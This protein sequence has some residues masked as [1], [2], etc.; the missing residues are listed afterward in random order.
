MAE[1]DIHALEARW[2]ARWRATGLHSTDLDGAR[3]PF[4]NLMEFPYPSGEGLHVG[5]VY[6]YAGADA[7]GRL[8]RMQGYDVFQPMGFDAFGIHSENYALKVGAHPAALIPANIARFRDEQLARLG[9]AFDWS[10]QLSTT[11]PAYYRWTQW[12]FVQL[13]R[14]GLA[15]QAEA[16]VNW[17]PRDQ[18]VLANEQV[19]GG[20]CERCDTPVERRELRQWFFR[21]SAYAERLLDYGGGDFPADWVARQRAWIGRSEGA[22]I[23][24]AVAGEAE[25]AT[26]F[27]TRPDTLF[28]ATFLALAPEHPLA[29]RIAAPERRAAVAAYI[30]ATRNRPERERTVGADKTGVFTGAFA[31]SPAGGAPVPIWVADYVLPHGGGAVMGVPAHDER[32]HAF[33][34]SFGLPVAPVVAPPGGAPLPYTGEGALVGSGPFSGMDSGAARGAIVAWLEGRGRGRGTVRYRLRDWLIS[35]QRYWGTPIPIVHC[36]RCGAQPVPEEQLPV[37]LPHVEA[38]RPTGVAPL[39]AVPE[40]VHTSCPGCGGPAERETDVS[41]TFLD[42]AWYFLRYPSTDR[43]DAPWD[44]AR[45]ARW[46]PVDQ[47]AGGP[48]HTTMHHLYARFIARALYDLGHLPFE[49]PFKRLRLH[50]TITRD[51]AKMSKSRGNVVSPDGY[52]AR[53]GADVTRMYMLFLGPWE[54]GGDF[55]DK[56]IG[57][58]ARFVGRLWTTLGGPAPGGEADKARV[59]EAAEVRRRL[60]ARVTEGIEGHHFHVAVAALMEALGWLRERGAGLGEAAWL[61][62]AQ[63]YVL[64]LAPLAPHLAEE[65]WARLGGPYSVHTQPWPA[66]GEQ[67]AERATVELAVQVAGRLRDR[68]VV[69]AGADDEAVRAAALASPRVRAILADRPPRRVIVVPGRVVNIVP[70]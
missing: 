69:P 57:G 53:Y 29:E 62:F 4:Y 32:D 63:E 56:G 14:A 35:R 24:F 70:A 59:A 17:C 15:Y 47:Y 7:L 50:G 54:E 26:V 6:T 22:E 37:L 18:T 10:R 49:E 41:D 33:A 42:S 25:P 20:R 46:L 31:A 13:F 19:V 66:A 67:P 16:P 1:L 21:I 38:F 61:A 2:R 5:H 12:L 48:E 27:T 60:V 45:T 51:G 23:D 30:A 52:I 40:F 8:R 64:L 68:I 65:L 34:L 43:D 55:S 9:C 44:P 11:D 36:A 58:V 3:R 39:A 28:G